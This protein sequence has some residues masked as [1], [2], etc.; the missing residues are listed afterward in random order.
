MMSH[1]EF[2]YKRS[3]LW[4]RAEPL[5][6][7]GFP[8]YLRWWDGK[9]VTVWEHFLTVSLAGTNPDSVS[10][11]SPLCFLKMT[12][13]SQCASSSSFLFCNDQSEHLQGRWNVY[14]T[15]EK[16]SNII[17]WTISCTFHSMS[18]S[19]LTA[20]PR[21]LVHH[22]AGRCSKSWCWSMYTS[23]LEKG[24]GDG[25]QECSWGPLLR[26]GLVFMQFMCT[27]LYGQLLIIP[28]LVALGQ[29]Y[30]FSVLFNIQ[31]TT[32]GA[33]NEFFKNKSTVSHTFSH[34]SSLI[35]CT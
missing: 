9:L 16:H 35:S 13:V 32:A 26:M 6:E 22:L 20:R 15:S 12:P 7:E 33:F 8:K 2:E 18:F 29:I 27:V 10:H 17:K 3:C 24:P 4:S 28:C 14:V 21:A 19:S 25:G 5:A 34:P 1:W 11:C 30:L 31:I 23:S